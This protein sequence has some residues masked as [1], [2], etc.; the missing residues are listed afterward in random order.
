M[1]GLWS[2]L[3]MLRKEISGRLLVNMMMIL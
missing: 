1:V 2:G 3:I